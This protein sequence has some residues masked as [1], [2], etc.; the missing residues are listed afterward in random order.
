MAV[1]DALIIVEGPQD[2]E[3]LARLLKVAG[4]MRVKNLRDLPVEWHNLVSNVF[5]KPSRGIDQSHAVPHFRK[6]A[7][8]EIVT[9]VIAGGDSSLASALMA[10]VKAFK[11]MPDAVGFVLDDD[12]EPN[13]AKRHEA[14]LAEISK[15]QTDIVLS[16]LTFPILPGQI[17]PGPPRAGIFVL[18]NNQGQGTLED[19]LLEAGEIAY[20]TQIAQAKEFVHNMKESGLN[21]DDLHE[22]TR[23]SGKK[24]QV[25][26]TVAALLKPG[27]ALATSLQDNRWLKDAAL[28]T[29]LV[30]GLRSWLHSLLNISAP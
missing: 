30:H 10:S 20:G 5:P 13:P 26:G 7:N 2:A 8:G 25:V 21:A 6:T 29:P 19:V 14:L 27:R 1:Q 17:Q 4:Y 23:Q 3:A 16:A 9:M 15:N 12:R 18:P 11:R 28:N 24:K 22:R